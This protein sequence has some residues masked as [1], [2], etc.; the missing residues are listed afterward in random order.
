MTGLFKGI[1]L[2]YKNAPVDIRENI[3]LG[4]EES[5][6]VMKH[7][8]DF[9]EAGEVLV[10]STCNRTEVYYS[11]ART[12]TRDIIKII[13]V[14]K[15]YSSEKLSPYF[16]EFL[17]SQEAV[18]HLFHVSIGL[19]SMVL[20]DIQITGQIK[21]SYQLSADMDM[22]G[23]FLHRLMHTIFFTN[24]R[25]VQE[26]SFRDGAASVSYASAELASELVK[27]IISPKALI[28]GVGE[29]GADTGRNLV[30]TNIEQVGV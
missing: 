13:G 1:S 17:D 19:E 8:K 21:D 4:A 26:T 12:L 2:S 7:I 29:M 3:A 15:G 27:G 25:I 23:P 14:V 20:G 6:Q 30:G 16:V 5:G 11:S 28:L 18:Q 22:A 9:T 24:K 10:V